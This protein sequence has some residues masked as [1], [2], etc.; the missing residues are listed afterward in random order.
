MVID[1]L[2][3]ILYISFFI[4]CLTIIR[5]SYYFI[6]A[7][8]SSTEEIPVKYRLTNTSLILLGISIAYLLTV[9]FTGIKI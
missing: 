6:Q 3:K 8:L 5:H 9:I 4:S 2:N 1:I 7:F